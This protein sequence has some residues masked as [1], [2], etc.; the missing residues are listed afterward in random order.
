MKLPFIQPALKLFV[1]GTLTGACAVEI[2]VSPYLYFMNSEIGSFHQF[3]NLL[4]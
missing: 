4:C 3:K 1:T 2:P